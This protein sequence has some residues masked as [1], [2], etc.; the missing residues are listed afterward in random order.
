MEKHVEG[1]V[2][3]GEQELKPYLVTYQLVTTVRLEVQATDE[4]HA[5]EIAE[6]MVNDGDSAAYE[7]HGMPDEIE[8]MEA[9]EVKP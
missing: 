5:E 9:V 8:N 2:M 4:D 3:S 7:P 6:K 1:E